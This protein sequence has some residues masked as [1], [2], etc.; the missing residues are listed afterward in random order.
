VSATANSIAPRLG[1]EHFRGASEARQVHCPVTTGD[2]M[3]SR[4]QALPP[5]FLKIDTEGHELSVLRG[6]AALLGG[7]QAPV[8]IQFEY[9]ATYLPSGTTLHSI[10]A[11]LGQNGYSLG[12]LYPD[13]VEF[14]TYDFDDDHFRMGNMIAVRDLGLKAALTNS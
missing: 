7:P 13:H 4:S 3:I 5:T 1:G 14:K 6:C 2:L 11:L 9:G 8:M 10:D 12:R